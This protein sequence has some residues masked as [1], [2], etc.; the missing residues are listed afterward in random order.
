MN[1]ESHHS[2]ARERF[3]RRERQSVPAARAFTRA[4]LADWEVR[5]RAYDIVLC[6]SE[7]ATNALVH[8]VPPGRGF[9]LRLLPYAGGDGRG[10]RVEVH[11]SGDGVPAI[12]Q[13]EVREPA[14]GGRGLLLV[15]ELADKWGVGERNPGKIVW[16]EFTDHRAGHRR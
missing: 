14:E 13:A 8:G 6:V 2:A 7:L 10:V 16:C 9:L 5:E 3:Y 1:T 15:S 4:V 12:P 11:D